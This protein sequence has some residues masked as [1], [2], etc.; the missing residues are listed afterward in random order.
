[1]QVKV[2]EQRPQGFANG[3]RVSHQ[4]SDLS[5][6]LEAKA[7]ADQKAEVPASG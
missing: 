6:G 4:V 2:Q 7:L 1:M 3:G 5:E